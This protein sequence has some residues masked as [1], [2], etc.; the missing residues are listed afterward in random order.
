MTKGRSF[1]FNDLRKKSLS[2]VQDIAHGFT[3]KFPFSSRKPDLDDEVLKNRPAPERRFSS[4]E[5]S[6]IDHSAAFRIPLL[7]TSECEASARTAHA[8][9]TA[10]FVVFLVTKMSIASGPAGRAR[11]AVKRLI[12]ARKLDSLRRHPNAHGETRIE[13][14]FCAIA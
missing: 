9:Q 10:C 12:Q 1:K 3:K 13:P 6:N 2:H 7:K 4:Q 5:M 8:A 14:F 11:L